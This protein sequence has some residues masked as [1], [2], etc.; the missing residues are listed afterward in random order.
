MEQEA[1]IILIQTL[2][3]LKEDV[4]KDKDIRKVFEQTFPGLE[5]E[6]YVNDTI[7]ELHSY[8]LEKDYDILDLSLEGVKMFFITALDEDFGWADDK[9]IDDIEENYGKA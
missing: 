4:L 3:K 8:A 6:D 5:F 2:N 9:M 7:K 1:L